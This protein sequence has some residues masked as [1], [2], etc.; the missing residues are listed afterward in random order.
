MCTWFKIQFH[1]MKYFISVFNCRISPGPVRTPLLEII[2]G[3]SKDPEKYL[4]VRESMQVSLK[5][6]DCN[7]ISRLVPNVLVILMHVLQLIDK[8]KSGKN[9]HK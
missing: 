4:K 3:A 8:N 2:A 7:H 5:P 6:V 1:S 9:V